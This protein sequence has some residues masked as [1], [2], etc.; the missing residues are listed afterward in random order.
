MTQLEVFNKFSLKSGLAV[1]VLVIEQ[2]QDY[3]DIIGTL[4]KGVIEKVDYVKTSEEGLERVL[5]GNYGL[6]FLD[7]KF[8][9]SGAKENLITRI[10]QESSVPVIGLNNLVDE[11]KGLNLVM[12]GADY[13]LQ[14]PFTPRRLRAA[15]TA[16]LR[17][18]QMGAAKNGTKNDPLFPENINS[19]GLSLSLGR[20]EVSINNKKI[21]LSSREFALLQLMMTNPKRAFTREE[22]AARAWGWAKGGEM[23]AV[24]STIKR[25]RR[26]IEE[27]GRH[28]QF[29]LTERNIGYRFYS[30]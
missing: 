10:R 28:P 22:L 6:V 9:N 21:S 20:L 2:D 30:E 17:R 15:V 13:D 3:A 5:N 26:K 7:S 19:N 27:K 8:S 1:K 23:R 4:L 11:E 24:D 16:V 18:S 25:L 14:K 29:I 12:N